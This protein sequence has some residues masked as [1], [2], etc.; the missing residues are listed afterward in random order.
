MSLAS[1][2]SLLIEVDCPCRERHA[3]VLEWLWFLQTHSARFSE[4]LFGDKDLFRLAFTLADKLSEFKQV[5]KYAEVTAI[6]SLL[7]N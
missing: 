2:A 6:W 1:L 5:R 3:D 4:L 7:C